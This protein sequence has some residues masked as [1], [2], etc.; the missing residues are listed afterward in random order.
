MKITMLVLPNGSMIATLPHADSDLLIG[1]NMGTIRVG[2]ILP[3]GDLYRVEFLCEEL[4]KYSKSG[5]TS[6]DLAVSYEQDILDSHLI[7]KFVV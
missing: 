4:K 7:E 2:N 6:Y 1:R 5:F 3:E